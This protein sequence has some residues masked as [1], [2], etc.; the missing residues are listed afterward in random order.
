[1][2]SKVLVLAAGTLGS[3]RLLLASRAR[4]PALSPQLGRRFS[5]NGDLLLFARGCKQTPSKR[6]RDLAP[7]KGPVIT[8]Y[9]TEQ[10]E[11]GKLWLEDA[12]GPDLSEWGWQLPELPCNAVHLAWGKR[13][14]LLRRLLGRG[15]SRT[16]ISADVAGVLGSARDSAAMLPML[17]M[18]YD[19]SGGRM[20]LDGD[21][22]ALDWDPAASAAHF[23]YAE[24]ALERVAR[25][26]GGELWPPA[27]WLRE[28]NWGLTVHPLGGCPMGARSSE[29]V[30]SARGEVFGCPGLFVADGSVMPGPVGP[31]PSLTIAAVA[32]CIADRAVE[33]LNRERSGAL[34]AP[35]T[36]LGD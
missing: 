20:R 7:S 8:A 21:E 5:S 31:N 4:L 29:G 25:G 30:V 14:E 34:A 32:D 36:S 19:R 35:A 9:A 33:R 16:R 6:P 22:L 10:T 23:R 28:R 26:L 2:R 27:Q 18:G 12:G 1:V 24:R 17:A 15:H 13:R 3:T 11:A